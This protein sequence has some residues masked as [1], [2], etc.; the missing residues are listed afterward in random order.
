VIDKTP[1]G[2][3]SFD[4]YSRLLN[5]RII[6][7]KSEVNPESAAVV[8]AQLLHLAA[9]SPDRDISLYL[10]TP[11]G[12]VTHG[13][14]IIDAM[15]HVKCDVQTICLGQCASMGAVILAAGSKGK[16]HILPNAEVMIHQPWGGLEGQQTD[17][18]LY[19]AR[20]AQTRDKLERM[21]SDFTGMKQGKIH[22][23]CDRD[24]WMNAE[25]SVE[26]GI[27]DSVIQ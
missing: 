1:L 27:V 12:S 3:R 22:E 18:A 23:D 7:L 17:L 8:V 19:A 24:F 20:M 21:L 16:R 4:I 13:L 15:N 5:E 6:F 9:V 10:S 14:A 11:G 2:E 26:Y 25:E